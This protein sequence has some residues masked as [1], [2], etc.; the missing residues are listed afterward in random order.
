ML[1]YDVTNRSSF[2]ALNGWLKEIRAHLENSSE[3]DSVVFV[4]CANKVKFLFFN[5]WLP[6]VL[7]LIQIC[8]IYTLVILEPCVE[9]T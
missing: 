2:E 3:I 8:A 1:V 4:V 5:F 7:G 9:L 6:F